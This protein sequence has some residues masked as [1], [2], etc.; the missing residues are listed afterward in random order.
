MREVAR[1]GCDVISKQCWYARAKSAT[2]HR[3]VFLGGFGSPSLA[4]PGPSSG[5]RLVLLFLG[6][7]ETSHR[8][9]VA[10]AACLTQ[11]P[12]ICIRC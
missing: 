2:D 1:S 9:T 4:S 5:E 8:M 12:E 6:T 11:Q 7:F 3:G 10:G